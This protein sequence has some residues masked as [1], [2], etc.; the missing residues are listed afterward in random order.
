MLLVERG[1]GSMSRY[2]DKDFQGDEERQAYIQSDRMNEALLSPKDS[3]K[4]L[5]VLGDRSVAQAMKEAREYCKEHEVAHRVKDEDRNEGGPDTFHR[6]TAR[7][8][9]HGSL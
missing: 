2:H 8:R 9:R 5:D 3:W 7:E 1:A 4:Q 6:R